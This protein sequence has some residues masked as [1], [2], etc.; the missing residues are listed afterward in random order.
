MPVPH[1]R[2][3]Y[4]LE[5]IALIQ[6]GIE[7]GKN[8]VV[9]GA[10]SAGLAAASG[11]LA[12]NPEPWQFYAGVFSGAAVLATGGIGAAL[13]FYI[14]GRAVDLTLLKSPKGG[15][16]DVYLDGVLET[17]ITTFSLGVVYDV[18]RLITDDA[19][20][21][22]SYAR[23][24]TLIN[25]QPDE[26]LNYAW[27]G[28]VGLPIVLNLID[29]PDPDAPPPRLLP[30]PRQVKQYTV[31]LDVTAADGVSTI[32]AHYPQAEWHQ[33]ETWARGL[34]ERINVMINGYVS[35]IRILSHFPTSDRIAEPGCSVSRRIELKA[36]S[37]KHSL[38]TFKE[39]FTGVSYKYARK[40]RMMA[41][42]PE[43]QA[44]AALFTAAYNPVI[45]V[46]AVDSRGEELWDQAWQVLR[47][48]TYHPGRKQP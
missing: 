35:E 12:E 9:A 24:V 14:I 27:M 44:L 31:E 4:G 15:A 18:H 20:N 26:D 36:G 1:M 33:V 48:S 30:W 38:P 22:R 8:A 28:I 17:T 5:A 13:S 21:G 10:T 43:T 25:R 29:P 11:F 41:D 40:A 32:T 45:G 37:F 39:D 7:V 42:T 6:Q 3:L 47:A 19:T 16:V 34:A 46:R 23:R 2:R